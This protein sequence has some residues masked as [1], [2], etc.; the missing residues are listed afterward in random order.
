MHDRRSA[1]A[2]G[3]NL[4][5]PNERK[6]IKYR[7]RKEDATRLTVQ[8]KPIERRTMPSSTE[9]GVR[10]SISIAVAMEIGHDEKEREHGI[11]GDVIDVRKASF[12]P[13]RRE[14]CA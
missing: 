12:N 7:K 9:S 5:I 1:A 3:I 2:S 6:P 10:L 13:E 8:E 11:E 4:A 14:R